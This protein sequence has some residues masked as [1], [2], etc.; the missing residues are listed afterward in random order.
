[1]I[2]FNF[3]G[4]EFWNSTTNSKQ[5]EQ[6]YILR[7]QMDILTRMVFLKKLW[8]NKSFRTPSEKSPLLKKAKFWFCNHCRSVSK[9][10]SDFWR[11]TGRRVAKLHST[12]PEAFL[13]KTVLCNFYF[14]VFFPQFEFWSKNPCSEEDSESMICLCAIRTVC[15]MF[16]EVCQKNSAALSKGFLSLQRKTLRKK[17]FL[18]CLEKTKKNCCS[19]RCLSVKLR[20]FGENFTTGLPISILRVQKTVWGKMYLGRR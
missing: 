14:R 10:L 13:T 7:V 6:N 15:K 1:M 2:C 17:L 12:C 19:F 3:F 16:S 9:K 8:L 4:F 20:R 18:G 5:V 11:Q